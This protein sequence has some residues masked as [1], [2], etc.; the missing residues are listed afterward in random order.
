MGERTA[1]RDKDVTA[2]FA[3]MNVAALKAD[4]TQQDPEITRA[5][6]GHGRSS[7]P[8]YVLYPA[9]PAGEPRMMQ[10]L[11]KAREVLDDINK[12]EKE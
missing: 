2:R 11:I 7:V 3:A 6:A 10:K 8:L 9:E 1:L 5:L 4:W 12:I